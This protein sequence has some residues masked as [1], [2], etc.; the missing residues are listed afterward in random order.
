MRVV[1]VPKKDWPEPPVKRIEFVLI[2]QNIVKQMSQNPGDKVEPDRDIKC[3]TRIPNSP[4]SQEGKHIMQKKPHKV[5]AI[6]MEKMQEA[7]DIAN[8]KL[9]NDT[10]AIGLINVIEYRINELIEHRHKG[11][12]VEKK[13]FPDGD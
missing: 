4:K 3:Q 9:I 13:C 5:F 2:I 10:S 6:I 12:K 11:G 1:L 7:N 8:N